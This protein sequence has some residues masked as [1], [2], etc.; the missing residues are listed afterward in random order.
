LRE[1]AN[2]TANRPVPLNKINDGIEEFVAGRLSP[3]YIR[4][5]YRSLHDVCPQSAMN[6]SLATLYKLQRNMKCIVN[7]DVSGRRRFDCVRKQNRNRVRYSVLELCG[8]ADA[9]A[10]RIGRVHQLADSGEDGGDGVIV[11]LELVL[12][13]IELLSKYFIRT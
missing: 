3:K 7:G 8:E 9:A 11:V 1:I 5:S 13:F 2:E 6:G 12:E 10:L 4:H